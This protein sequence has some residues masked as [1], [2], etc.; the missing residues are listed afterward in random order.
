MKFGQLKEYHMKNI[1]L[2]K[3]YTKCGGTTISIPFSKKSKLSL[4]LKQNLEFY[5]ACFFL[6]A[7]LRTIKIY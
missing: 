4:S 6:Y 7:K 3:S 2:E 5:T 1:F